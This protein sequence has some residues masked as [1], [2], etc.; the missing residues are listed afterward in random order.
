MKDMWKKKKQEYKGLYGTYQSNDFLEVCIEECT[1]HKVA[2]RRLR[3]MQCHDWLCGFIKDTVPF[4]LGMKSKKRFKAA[5]I[6]LDEI[7]WCPWIYRA[8][9]ATDRNCISKCFKGDTSF[10]EKYRFICPTRVSPFLISDMF[11]SPDPIYS[12]SM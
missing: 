9:N 6:V 3:A 2:L 7:S 8:V 10:A 1:T 12:V 5:F 11:D 4:S